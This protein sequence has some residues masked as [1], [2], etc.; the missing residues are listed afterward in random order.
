MEGELGAIIVRTLVGVVITGLGFAIRSLFV[1]ARELQVKV[2][3]LESRPAPDNS[4]AR[5]ARE[6]LQALRLCIAERYTLRDDYVS[7][8]AGVLTRLDGIGTIVAR[9]E[10]RQKAHER[11]HELRPD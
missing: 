1:R 4:E 8:M 7:Q 11:T 6:E 10:E 3:T 5:K 9:V 2:A